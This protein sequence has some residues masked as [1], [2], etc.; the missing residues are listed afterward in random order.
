MTLQAHPPNTE[1]GTIWTEESVRALLSQSLSEPLP[2]DD[3]AELLSRLQA[4]PSQ[5]AV[6]HS[7]PLEDDEPG[8][9]PWTTLP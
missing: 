8:L 5:L 3:L 1:H 7:L 2:E 6:L 9:S 4:L